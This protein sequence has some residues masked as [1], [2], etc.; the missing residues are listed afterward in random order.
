[1]DA[2]SRTIDAAVQKHDYPALI[3][4][5]TDSN[6]PAK[7]HNVGQGEQRSVAAHFIQTAVASGTFFP[8]AFDNADVVQVVII[9]LGHLPSTVPNAADNKLRHMLF[10][11]KVN[12]EGDYA[13][14]ARILG[15]TRMEDDPTSVYH[16]SPA[17]KCDVYVKI[18]ECFLAEDLI[19][20]SDSAVTKAGSV[21]EG[22][23]NPEEH[24]ALILRYKSTYA[25]VLDA[26]R[27]FL[28][29]AQR[30]HDL[31]LS[32][33]DA[34][35]KDD[36]LTMLGRA[37]TC[38]I[39]AP[40]GPQRH[41]VLGHIYKDKRLSQLDAMDDFATHSKILEKNYMH[42]ILRKEELTKFEQSLQPHQRAIMGDG[43]TIVERGVVEHNMIA[44]SM[45]YRSIYVKELAN[46]LGVDPR[47]AEKLASTMIMDGSLNGSID[48]IEGL[49]EFQ[50]DESPQSYFDGSITNFCIE[51]NAV[52]DAVKAEA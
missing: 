33:T 12:T 41:R 24:M 9:A 11:Y 19:A 46:I 50:I 37:A 4:V 20:E 14:A 7:W 10:D 29:A 13:G 28:Q 21:V 18:A 47:K 3:G 25:R 43:L 27:K 15:G 42:Q 30:Y 8:R 45:L 2:L 32:A 35:D 26:N 52:A 23:K 34:I 16:T 51:L 39:L 1:M 31:S 5:F 38:A 6:G 17:E 36:L 44:V 22:I 40:S 49:L 48:Q